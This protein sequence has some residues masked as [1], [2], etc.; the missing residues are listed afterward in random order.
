M[1]SFRFAAPAFLLLLTGCVSGP[2][3]VPPE[4][5]LP[6]K[7]NEG[8][9]K[10]D[11][12]VSTVAWWTAYRDTRLNALVTEGLSEN[13]S[14]QQSLERINAA[15]AGVTVAGAGSLPSLVVGA[16][17]TTSGDL[18]SLAT[19]KAATN[20][21]G[22]NANVSWLL[23]LFGQYRRSKESA[24]ASL[25][26]AYSTADV[27]KLT[28][29]QDLVN[30]Y[31][32]ARYYQERI[33]LSRA[34][35]K[36][37][38]ETYDLTKFQLDAGAASRLDVV[39]A[40]GLVQSTQ[41]EIPG[42]ETSFRIAAHRIA[43]LL[44][45]PAGSMVADL[46]R[47]GPQ[48]VFRAGIVS[49]VPADLIRNRPD[50]RVAERNLAAA[51]ANIGVAMSQLYPSISLSG[52]I[53][54]SY[55]RPVGAN[56]GLTSWSFGPTLTLPIFDGGR[57]RANVDIAK[58]DAKTQYLAWKQTVLQAVEEVENALSAVRRDAQTVAA[59]RAQVKTT[60]ETLDLS[61][62]SYK[63]G[64]SSLLDVLDAQRQVSLA[65]AS[66]AAAVQQMAIDYV[67]LNVAIGGG[68]NPGGATAPKPVA[69]KASTAKAG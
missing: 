51:T 39:Q 36:S 17:N 31:I 53:S 69:A 56:G 3:H 27:A 13:L 52:S 68:Y 62:A 59:L 44:G 9:A 61:T 55:I 19:T 66:L 5:P 16:S 7:F 48:P 63:D 35:L 67:S 25:D 46:Q 49:G 37:R 6:A 1:A 54:P 34:N 18:G 40:E 21:T 11:G 8:A 30:S 32:N 26:A 2:D 38:Q 14:I 23:D 64:A 20:T 47:A 58:S 60:Q 65:Q 33:A 29:L 45:K 4:M 28:Y 41:A 43:T 22:A 15:A 12:D 42:L 24:Q 50:I 10:P 57:L